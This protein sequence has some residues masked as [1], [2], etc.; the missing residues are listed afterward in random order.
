M[1]RQNRVTPFSTLIATPTR[2]TLLGNRGVLHDNHGQIK[3]QY[4]GQRWIICVLHFKNRQRRIM[5]PGQ[6]TELFFLDEATAL[7]AGHRPCAE[8]QRDRFT[9][10]RSLWA[11]ANPDLAG[12]PKPAATVIDA[13][14]H[15]ERVSAPEQTLRDCDSLAALPAGTFITDDGQNAYLWLKQRLLRWQPAGYTA[16]DH[17]ALQFPASI[18]TA[19]SLV[20]TLAAGY[21]VAIHPSALAGEIS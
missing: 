13:A 9:L 5:T 16:H 14:L 15:A 18:L 20:R 6:Y 1:P 21:P 7:A 8:C 4:Q 17:A 19:A 3:R 11:Q 12:G 2:G 10:I